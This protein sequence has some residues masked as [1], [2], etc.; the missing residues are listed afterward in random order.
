MG[1]GMGS[2][3]GGGDGNGASEGGGMGDGGMGRGGNRSGDEEGDGI[4]MFM[5]VHLGFTRERRESWKAP[6]RRVGGDARPW[7]VSTAELST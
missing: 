5:E 6:P 1:N 3:A 4:S 2:G 7:N